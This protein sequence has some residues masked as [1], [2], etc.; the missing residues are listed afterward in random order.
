MKKKVLKIFL[1]IMMIFTITACGSKTGNKWEYSKEDRAL[2]NEVYSFK[3]LNQNESDIDIIYIY[4]IEVED[5]ISEEDVLVFNYDDLEEDENYEYVSYDLIKKYQINTEKI[6]IK[7]EPNSLLVYFYG[8][9]DFFT[10]YGVLINK[11]VTKDGEYVITKT[12]KEHLGN[13]ENY[14]YLTFAPLFSYLDDKG[15]SME[16][17]IENGVITEP[18]AEKLANND[19]VRLSNIGNLISWM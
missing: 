13:D 18:I 7:N 19:N 11:D 3:A 9:N 6:E 2:F 15:I 12:Q 1:A 8:D 4:D 17:L 10:N 14:K 16:K 5:K